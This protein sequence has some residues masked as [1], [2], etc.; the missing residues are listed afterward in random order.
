MSFARVRALVVVGVLAVAAVVFVIVAL[1]QDTQGGTT[2]GEGCPAG[3]PLADLRL[4]DDPAEVT[5]KVF[6]GTGTAGL[7]E[8]VTNEF[9]NRRFTVQKPGESKTK[10]K[11]VAEIRY[12][13]DTV[14]KAQ[15]LRAYF[16]AQSKMSYSAKRKGA[17]IE[18]VIGN[19]FRQLATT[20]EVNQSLVE[21]GEPTLPPG[22]CVKPADKDS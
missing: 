9:K 19:Q 20:T 5:V 3:A 14:G 13:P 10:L 2:A 15:L 18:I 1:V 11:G 7:A 6:N 12:G 8:N 4:P 16:L 22:A 17:V 21:V